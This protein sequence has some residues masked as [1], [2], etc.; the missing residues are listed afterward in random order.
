MT[1]DLDKWTLTSSTNEGSRVAFM[2]QVW[3]KSIKICWRYGQMLTFFYK[4]N[5]IQYTYKNSDYISLF[6][7]TFQTRQKQL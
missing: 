1:F 2:I 7:T 6:L 3:L 4:K 5:H